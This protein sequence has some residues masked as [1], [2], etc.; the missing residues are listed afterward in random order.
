MVLELCATG[1][2]VIMSD[3]KEI[4]DVPLGRAAPALR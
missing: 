1:K 2:W 3:K 4:R